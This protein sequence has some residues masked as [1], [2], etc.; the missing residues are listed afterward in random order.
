MSTLL[1]PV[2]RA[3]E[4]AAE[5]SVAVEDRDRSRLQPSRAPEAQIG[6]QD[7]AEH[8]LGAQPRAGAGVEVEVVSRERERV[9]DIGKDR[10]VQ[11]AEVD[12][13]GPRSGLDVK[14]GKA[15]LRGPQRISGAVKGVSRETSKA[16][17]PSRR[18]EDAPYQIPLL[19]AAE[20][21]IVPVRQIPVRD[22]ERA[23]QGQRMV[24]GNAERAPGQGEELRCGRR[25]LPER[26]LASESRVGKT[27][28]EGESLAA[29]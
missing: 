28:G 17:R 3:S 19:E 4:H 24:P 6:R 18:V 9:A 29:L 20:E 23:A 16:R 10:G 22:A 27:Q 7:P 1:P 8:D 11:T 12:G 25:R 2:E 26:E 21:E 14:E 15:V 13:Q 5:R